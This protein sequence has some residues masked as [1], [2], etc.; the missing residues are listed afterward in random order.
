MSHASELRLLLHV[1]C[2]RIFILVIPIS[3]AK[4]PNLISR[5][6]YLLYRIFHGTGERNRGYALLVTANR[7]ETALYR[8]PTFSL[9][10]VSHGGI[11]SCGS[12]RERERETKYGE[13]ERGRNTQGDRE[14][15]SGR[16]NEGV[17]SG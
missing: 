16:W 5:Q 17:R 7:P 9:L 10:L 12:E 3:I 11:S 15:K 14:K 1:K 2:S 8:A 4:S 6:T 13:R